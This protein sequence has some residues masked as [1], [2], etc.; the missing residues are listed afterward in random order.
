[1]VAMYH[2]ARKG[3]QMGPFDI[4][5]LKLMASRGQLQA[6]DLVW[7]EGLP[8][9]E[10]ADSI[11]GIF[12]AVQPHADANIEGRA[13]SVQN[14]NIHMQSKTPAQN[15]G[16]RYRD[17]Y[18]TA[19]VTSVL[20]LVVKIIGFILGSLIVAFSALTGLG[21]LAN[22]G[23]QNFGGVAGIAGALF[24]F[25]AVYGFLIGFVFF[26]LGTLLSAQGQLLL[27]T[28]DGTVA[29]SPFLDD[30]EKLRIMG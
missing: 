29:S 11:P 30:E 23:Q 24:V 10:R 9:W 4:E 6:T 15:L 28:L 5:K 16:K 3:Q 1:M 7:T 18:R 13:V 26:V 25:G 22:M 17:A 14:R 8:A 19:K 2:V 21:G 27:A 12:A 20:G